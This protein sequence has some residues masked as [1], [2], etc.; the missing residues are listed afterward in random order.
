MKKFLAT[1]SAET[2]VTE[3][4]IVETPATEPEVTE[5]EVTEPEPAAPET[6]DTTEPGITETTEPETTETETT[7]PE[8]TE[9]ESFSTLLLQIDNPTGPP[10][11]PGPPTQVTICH[12]DQSG[13][14][15][16]ITISAAALQAAGHIDPSANDDHAF[17]IVPPFDSYGGKNYSDT[18]DNVPEYKDDY[19]FN[20]TSGEDI[21]GRGC[22]DPEEED[23]IVTVNGD[24][25][26]E[27]CSLEE[28]GVVLP[29]S[30]LLT[31]V[32]DG[33]SVTLPNDNV[34]VEMKGPGDPGFSAVTSNSLTGLDDGTY[35][36][37]VSVDEGYTLT[38]PKNFSE[39]VGNQDPE[40]CDLVTLGPVVP[41]F[42]PTPITCNAAG[43]FTIGNNETAPG[44]DPAAVTW[45]IGN[46]LVDIAEG[47]H[48]V[49][50]PGS[51]H[52][53]ATANGPEWF[54]DEDTQH[55]FDYQFTAP[56]GCDLT[57]LALTGNGD[58]TPA[59][60]LTAFLGLLG[61]AM[62]RSGA[63]VNR[64]RQEA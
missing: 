45:K 38:T 13:K 9:P 39:E 29:G 4:P 14:W 61:L 60:A 33:D 44:D 40:D 21:L 22:A 50:T 37:K 27:S 55:V 64:T 59:L 47:T 41:F 54:F 43:S 15:N 23:V 7:E 30:I 56:T 53:E 62:A 3:T 58:M 63:R 20:G 35:M 12:W 6:T 31:V 36:F 42:T 48:V 32:V 51:V 34:T 17:D 19:P 1:V 24:P 5:P 18:S 10:E 25:T 16:D 49:S 52:L 26:D 46:P 57:T 28:E 8:T 11:D 2:A